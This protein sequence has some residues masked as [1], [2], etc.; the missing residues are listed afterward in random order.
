VD[1]D[2]FSPM[3]FQAEKAEATKKMPA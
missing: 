2:R 1:W 3:R